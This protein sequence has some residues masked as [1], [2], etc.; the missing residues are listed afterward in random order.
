MRRSQLF[1]AAAAALLASFGAQAAAPATAII[2]A[3]QLL[4]V[5]GRDPLTNATVVVT[6]GKVREIRSG[7]ADPGAVGLPADT[8]VINLRTSSCY[9]VSSTCTCT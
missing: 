2:H 4:A 9:P 1:G 3:G 6:D 7:F 5:P 8:A